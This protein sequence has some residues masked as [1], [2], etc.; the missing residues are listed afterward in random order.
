MEPRAIILNRSYFIHL[1]SRLVLILVRVCNTTSDWSTFLFS[2]NIG[3]LGPSYFSPLPIV[4]L[5]CSNVRPYVAFPRQPRSG[6]LRSC[7]ASA[8]SW[9]TAFLLMRCEKGAL[10]PLC[11]CNE[12]MLGKIS[13]PERRAKS[14]GS[15]RDIVREKNY[16]DASVRPAQESFIRRVIGK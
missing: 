14:A 13:G 5:H 9:Q 15:W 12:Q 16:A 11:K 3:N 1:K 10:L 7:S 4:M 8:P 2:Q 6:Q